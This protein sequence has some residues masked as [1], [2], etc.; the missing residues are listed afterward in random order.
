MSTFSGNVLSGST[1]GRGIKVVAT[2]TMGT[3]IHT[4]GAGTTG[5][6]ECYLW[7]TNSDSVPRLLTI[8]WG[9]T[10]SPDDLIVNALSIPANSGPTI[11]VPGIRL[12]N[13]KVIT[14]FASVANVLIITGQYNRVSA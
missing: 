2:A 12:N 3:T 1:N 13:G 9:G 4:A 10:V 11:V 7:V 8:E 6:D 14:A 5:F